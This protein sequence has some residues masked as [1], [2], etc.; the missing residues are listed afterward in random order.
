MYKSTYPLA[1]I[2]AKEYYENG[3]KTSIDLILRTRKK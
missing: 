2:G 3:K 1:R